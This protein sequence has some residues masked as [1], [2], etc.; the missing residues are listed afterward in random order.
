MTSKERVMAALSH[1]EPDRVPMDFGSTG[2]TGIH[3]SCVANLRDY[4]GL[5]R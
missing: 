1:R 4:F 5:A 2:V 3:V